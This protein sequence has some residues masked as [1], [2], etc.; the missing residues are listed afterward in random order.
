[1]L[2]FVLVIELGM[3]SDD[4]IGDHV[5]IGSDFL[6]LE[7]FIVGMFATRAYQARFVSRYSCLVDGPDAVD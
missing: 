3:R 2:Y 5:R 6:L 4:L 1:M 7:A